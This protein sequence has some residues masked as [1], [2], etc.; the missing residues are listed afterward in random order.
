MT[1]DQLRDRAEIMVEQ[2]MLPMGKRLELQHLLATLNAHEQHV[3]CADAAVSA[4]A[5][6]GVSLCIAVPCCLNCQHTHDSRQGHNIC[7][8]TE[9]LCAACI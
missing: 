3:I 2:A 8:R 5:K 6:V 4:V 1:W 7:F 9:P